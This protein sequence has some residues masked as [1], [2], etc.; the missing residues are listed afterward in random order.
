MK[1]SELIE[2]L[3]QCAPYKKIIF[4]T[5]DDGFCVGETINKV[6]EYDDHVSLF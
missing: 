3:Q 5:E 4:I 6:V 1:V 2:K